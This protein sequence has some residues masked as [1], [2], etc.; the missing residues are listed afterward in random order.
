PFVADVGP[1]LVLVGDVPWGISSGTNLDFNLPNMG[2]KPVN[3]LYVPT[4]EEGTFIQLPLDELF[5]GSLVEDY[6]VIVDVFAPDNPTGSASL[7]EMS[8]P[9]GTLSLKL[10]SDHYVRVRTASVVGPQ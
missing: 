6:T 10:D 5:E 4:L 7:F 9:G 3:V 1:D 2:G 8:N